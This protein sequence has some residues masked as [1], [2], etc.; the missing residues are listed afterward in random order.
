MKHLIAL[1]KALHARPELS[2]QERESAAMVEEFL[3]ELQPDVL[4]SGLGGHGVLA[5]FESGKPG[6]CILF[7]AELDALPIDEK[8]DMEHVS[9]RPG[10]SHKC[11]H[12]G[13]AVILCGLAEWVAQHRPS[14]G[15]IHLLWQPAEET[16]EGAAAVLADEAFASVSPNWVFALHNLPGY[17][18]GLVVCKEGTF[19]AAVCSMIIRLEGRTAHSA[20]PELGINPALGLAELLQGSVALSNNRPDREDFTLVTPVHMLLGSPSYGISAGRGELHLTLRC[21]NNERLEAL[22]QKIADLAAEI[23]G[24]EKLSIDIDKTEA[25]M[26]N[27]NDAPALN[28][29]RKAA[30]LAELA[31][32]EKPH[33]FKWGEDFGQFS[34]RFSGCMIG[35]GAGEDQPVLHSPEYD[36]PDQII[37]PGIAL[38][39]GIIRLIQESNGHAS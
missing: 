1:R 2:G 16:G 6:P 13:H 24:R 26:A 29:V 15:K 30:E 11:G 31:L 39:S 27:S 33:P 14:T 9:K 21:W 36:F 37:A 8:N 25:F 32:F 34:S 19:S 35:L 22:W 5:S 23:A 38:F 4:L 20:E 10:V 12:D 18:E 7:R 17:S 28:L 3:R